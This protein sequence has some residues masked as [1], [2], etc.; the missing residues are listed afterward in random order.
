MSVNGLGLLEVS[1]VKFD[2]EVSKGKMM[3]DFPSLG[4]MSSY[5]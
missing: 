3:G 2:R 1:V 4:W 5:F